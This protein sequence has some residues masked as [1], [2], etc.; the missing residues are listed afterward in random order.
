V[1]F[2]T[3]LYNSSAFS[4]DELI[5][6][7]KYAI[8]QNS[9]Y[10]DAEFFKKRFLIEVD[11]KKQEFNCECNKLTRDGLVCCHVL[12]LFTQLGINQLPDSCINR[13]W[14]KMFRE[15]ELEK[16]IET[17][18]CS[19]EQKAIRYA[20]INNKV[21]SIWQYICNG[22]SECKEFLEELEKFHEKIQS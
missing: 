20:M 19:K 11:R 22:G 7:N 4:V 18:G 10:K 17:N 2:Q 8:V 5:K 15:E 12:R 3:E 16:C 13:R 21:S 1:K 9:Y 6:D 14:T